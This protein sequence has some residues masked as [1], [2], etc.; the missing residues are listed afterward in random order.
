VKTNCLSSSQKLELVP[1]NG[2]WRQTWP[3]FIATPLDKRLSN[4]PIRCLGYVFKQ[5][6]SLG[7]KFHWLQEKITDHKFHWLQDNK[8]KGAASLHRILEPS[9]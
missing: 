8:N 5:S 3:L 4:I 1:N 6:C 9:I 2:L 7:L